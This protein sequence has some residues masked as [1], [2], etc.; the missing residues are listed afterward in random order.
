MGLISG[1]LLLPLAPVRGTAWV[2]DL[3]L[4]T[5]ERELYSCDALRAQLAALNHAYE[6]GDLGEEE[7]E[8]QEERLLDLLEQAQEKA[9]AGH[10][11]RRD[12]GHG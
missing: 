5:A 4:D 3:L 7:F 9:R 8:A 1:L 6:D 11:P 2:A 12:T 10:E